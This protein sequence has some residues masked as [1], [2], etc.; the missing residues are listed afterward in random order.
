M[1]LFFPESNE[2]LHDFVLQPLSSNELHRYQMLDT[3]H[4]DRLTREAS[5]TLHRLDARNGA[6]DEVGD[7]TSMIQGDT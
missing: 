4:T 1:T 6:M 2:K 7:E 3:P 5:T